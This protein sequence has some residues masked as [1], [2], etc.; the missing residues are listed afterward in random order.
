[1]YPMDDHMYPIQTVARKLD[2][3]PNVA[4]SRAA[5]LRKKGFRC[6]RYGQRIWRYS[7]RDVEVLAG[8]EQPIVHVRTEDRQKE[9]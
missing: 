1:G 3:L 4:K 2:V 9:P 7:E 6:G 8:R 5:R